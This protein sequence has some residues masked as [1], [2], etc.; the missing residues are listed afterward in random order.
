MSSKI[1][2]RNTNNH[3]DV[4]GTFNPIEAVARTRGSIFTFEH[5]ERGELIAKIKSPSGKLTQRIHTK[6]GL[7]GEGSTVVYVSNKPYKK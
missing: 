6:N 5:T 3:L 4:F 1:T 2:E 7:T